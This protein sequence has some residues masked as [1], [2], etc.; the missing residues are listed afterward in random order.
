M[1][2]SRSTPMFRRLPIKA[3]GTDGYPRA[4]L[5]AMK[6]LTCARC[7]QSIASGEHFTQQEAPTPIK[8]TTTGVHYNRQRVPTCRTCSPFEEFDPW[9]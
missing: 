8:V 4:C 1:T 2:A 9:A 6:T 5:E 3:R 7:E